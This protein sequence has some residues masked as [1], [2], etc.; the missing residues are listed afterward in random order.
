MYILSIHTYSC[1]FVG[2]PDIIPNFLKE[3]EENATQDSASQVQSTN[4]PSI[5]ELSDMSMSM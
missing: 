2:A 1:F 4:N 5:A 3:D